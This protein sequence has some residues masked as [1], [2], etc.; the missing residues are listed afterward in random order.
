MVRLNT[1]SSSWCTR[2]SLS[3]IVILS[4]EVKGH[5]AFFEF[6]AVMEVCACVCLC[7]CLC[8]YYRRQFH[9]MFQ[10]RQNLHY[11]VVIRNVEFCR[12]CMGNGACGGLNGE[13]FK[14]IG[15]NLHHYERWPFLITNARSPT[16]FRSHVTHRYIHL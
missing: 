15:S 1:M 9:L 12:R 11:V 8:A 13:G 10:S 16:H 7:W 5:I 3:T 14:S 6:E 2:S 4:K